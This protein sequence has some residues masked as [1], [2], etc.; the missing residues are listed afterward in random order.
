MRTGSATLQTLQEPISLAMAL[1][2]RWLPWSSSPDSDGN[3]GAG[4]VAGAH[5]EETLLRHEAAHVGGP[6]T[7][8]VS[9]DAHLLLI[10]M[11][12]EF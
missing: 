5:G 10:E 1:L 7:L 6:N 3:P 2:P 4:T 9:G 11:T 12:S 8:A